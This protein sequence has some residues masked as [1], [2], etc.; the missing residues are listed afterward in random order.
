MFSRN[1]MINFSLSFYADDSTTSDCSSPK[2]RIGVSKLARRVGSFKDDFFDKI[3]LIRSPSS[4]SSNG[5]RSSSPKSKNRHRTG[6]PKRS[7]SPTCDL[8]DDN[9]LKDLE[10]HVKQVRASRRNERIRSI[11][12][13]IVSPLD[14]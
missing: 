9:P 1:S 10:T 5:S 13:R 6:S 12:P 8:A 4:M 3:A 2:S 7:G 11:P 14:P